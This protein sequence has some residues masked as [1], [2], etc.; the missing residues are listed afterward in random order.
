MS[1]LSFLIF[2]TVSSIYNFSS[3]SSISLA[4]G[5]SIFINNNYYNYSLT[6]YL[7]PFKKLYLY[8]I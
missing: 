7:T 2:I 6:V 8:S 5:S 1:P 4:R 3:F